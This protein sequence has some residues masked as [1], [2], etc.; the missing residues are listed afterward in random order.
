MFR[1]FKSESPSRAPRKC[2]TAPNFNAVPNG[3]QLR[4]RADPQGR[5][6]R[7]TFD[8]RRY[9]FET[10][11]WPNFSRQVISFR[12]LDAVLKALEERLQ[13]YSLLGRV[14]RARSRSRISED[15][16]LSLCEPS[17]TSVAGP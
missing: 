8:I 11:R 7:I 14:A 10:Q 5:Q 4:T 2:R 1:A 15:S 6:Q 17:G 12:C 3:T 9:R 16:A 13:R